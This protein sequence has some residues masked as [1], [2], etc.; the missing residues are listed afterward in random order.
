MANVNTYRLFQFYLVIGLFV[1]PFVYWPWAAI[2]YEIP[3][4]WFV[5]RWIEGLGILGCIISFKQSNT[6]PLSQA[7]LLLIGG[8]LA[9]LVA[10]SILGVDW[11]KSLVGNYYRGDGIFTL[12]H[13]LALA[14]AMALFFDERMKL[15]LLQAISWGSVMTS[16]WSVILAVRY[17]IGH[18]TSVSTW[19]GAIGA[20]FGQPK[21]LT[22]YLLITLPIVAYLLA[23]A[24]RHRTKIY[25]IGALTLQVLAIAFTKSWAGLAGVCLFFLGWAL[26]GKNVRISR[27]VFTASILGLLLVIAAWGYWQYTHQL[28]LYIRAEGRERIIIKGILAFT[29]RPI[30]GWGWANFDHAFAA[31]DWPYK[32]NVDAY[33]D[34]AHSSFLEVLV[35]TGIIGFTLYAILIGK[36][37][38]SLYARNDLWYRYLLFAFAL[39]LFHAQTNVLSIAEE[40][41]FWT[42]IGITWSTKN[43]RD[44]TPR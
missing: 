5:Q 3:R 18:D 9:S 1:L 32:F 6:R 17:Y 16:L 15:P 4:V 42:I 10:S 2:P 27:Y 44:P 20:T 36:S 28:P 8:F 35:T 38:Q 39:Y 22:G 14:V 12:T 11:H 31:V 29:K 13:L 40:V 41:I 19:Q 30:L 25:W 26:I 21:F 33:V 23:T 43:N 24:T 7:F 37:M 34:K